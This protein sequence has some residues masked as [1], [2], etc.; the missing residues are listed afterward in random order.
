MTIALS[1][2]VVLH[3]SDSNEWYTP[4]PIV[5]AARRVLGRIELDPASCAEANKVV[6]ATRYY[7]IADDGLQQPWSGTI[8]LNPPYGKTGNR[9]NQDIW[10]RRLAQEYRSGQVGAA[11]LLVNAA[12]DTA[13]F[14]SLGREFPICL[15]AGRLKFWR[16]DVPA[17]SPTHGSALVYMGP[18]TGPF[19]L[20]CKELGISAGMWPGGMQ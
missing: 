3:S 8:W 19:R 12:T 10:S 18:M 11:M 17:D 15:I 5:A 9:S 7:T 13:W 14:Q 1:P 4:A 6:Q 20:L 2:R 16:S